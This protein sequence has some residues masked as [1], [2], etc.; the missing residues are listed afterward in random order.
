MGKGF[1]EFSFSPLEDVISVISM[2]S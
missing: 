2:G 1:Y